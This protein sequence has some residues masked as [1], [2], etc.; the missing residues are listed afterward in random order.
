V[1]GLT[2]VG[3]T[4]H[5]LLLA[6]QLGMNYLSASSLML[7]MMSRASD[8]SNRLWV[9]HLDAVEA[10]R[11]AT[12]VDRRVNESLAAAGRNHPATVFDSWAM[13]F[14][15]SE[16]PAIRD[17]SI[18]IELTSDEASRAMKCVVSQ[19][20]NPDSSLDEARAVIQRKDTSTR[21]RF[22]RDF[23][24]DVFDS[25][26]RS[27]VTVDLSRHVYGT[28]PSQVMRGVRQAHANLFQEVQDLLT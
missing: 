22:L 20:P 2:A 25:T 28:A 23:A 14:L 7:Q 5:A 4:T 1:S 15:A 27:D 9:N 16:D 6:Q 8:G 12:D 19:G 17:R 21:E 24:F 10:E 18:V 3:K 26:D 13:P 11:D